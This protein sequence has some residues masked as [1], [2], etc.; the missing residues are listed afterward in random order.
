MFLF[1]LLAVAT[2][3]AGLFVWS[4]FYRPIAMLAEA[5]ETAN[6][7]FYEA[8]RQTAEAIAQ[9]G[10]NF[11]EAQ[12]FHARLLTSLGRTDEALGQFS[13]IQQPE[14]L[15]ADLLCDLAKAAMSRG[16][17][18]LAKKALEAVGT[19]SELYPHA[20]RALIQIHLQAGREDLAR[21]MCLRLLDREPTDGT[22]WQVLGTI[23]MNR[24]DLAEAEDAFRRCLKLSDDSNQSQ[25]VRAD[26]IQ[27]LI[28]RGDVS[29]A[30][31]ELTT[32]RRKSSMPPSERTL[33]EEAWLLRLE[34]DLRAGV[35][36]LEPLIA[37]ENEFAT[38]AR[39]L[40]GLL[41][42]D[43]E[44]NEKASADLEKVIAVQPWN[45]EAHHKLGVAYSRLGQSDK[46]AEH[47][48]A[49]ARLLELAKELLD[50]SNDLAEDPANG[51]LRQRVAELYDQLGQPGEARR[52]LGGML[53]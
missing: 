39:F 8:E 7:D 23:A 18:L 42:V 1:L 16:E 30:R 37:R 3:S 38:R 52:L 33:L 49:S 50:R 51:Q 44:E 43:L 26:L 19:N 46:A 28:D 20:Q 14:R 45:K 2:G 11:P 31:K 6:R 35:E 22:A 9:A 12:L 5:R 47:F 21:S 15:P 32:L 53:R 34:G 13:L 27:I 25:D 41:Y 10:G 24:K 48:A 36:L 40:R 17:T 4:R 29:G